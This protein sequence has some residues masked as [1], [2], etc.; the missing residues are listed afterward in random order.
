MSK[1]RWAEAPFGLGC[2][3]IVPWWREFAVRVLFIVEYATAIEVTESLIHSTALLDLPL[4]P[5]TKPVDFLHV[6]AC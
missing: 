2:L 6:W 5:V 3:V 1:E 4:G